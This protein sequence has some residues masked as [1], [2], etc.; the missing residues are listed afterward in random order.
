[1]YKH[2]PLTFRDLEIVK[3][4]FIERLKTM[5]HARISYPELKV[6]PKIAN[7]VSRK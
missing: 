2:T 5:Y 7:I 3:E 4:V 6:K 1:M